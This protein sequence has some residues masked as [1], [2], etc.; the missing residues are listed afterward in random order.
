MEVDRIGIPARSRRQV[1]DW[2]LVLASQGIEAILGQSEE[3]WEVVVGARD[4]ERARACLRQYQA[5]N[6]GWHWQQPLPAAGVVFHWGSAG[7]AVVMAAIYYWSTTRFPA[8]RQLGIMDSGA[9]AAGQW[10]RLFTA[11]SLHENMPHLMANV[12]TGFVLLGLAMARYGAGVGLLASFLAGAA[13]NVA[14]LALYPQPHEGLGASGMVMGAL[15]LI[16]AQSFAFWR[17]CRSASHF[18]L[19]SLAAGVLILV[20]I[21]FSPESDIVAHVGGFVCGLLCGWALGHARAETLQGG[22]AN[23]A[24]STAVVALLVATWHMAL[25]AP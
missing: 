3:G 2:G 8:A 6:R 12:T 10:W 14:G 20:L 19:R 16:T 18:W 23:L 13:G 17:A 22:A 21:G 11:V 25:R 24:A 5:E 1:M 9:V 4:Y 15:G 7:W